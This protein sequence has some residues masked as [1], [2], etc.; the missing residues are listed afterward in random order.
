MVKKNNYTDIY[1]NYGY[2]NAK[3]FKK[4]EHIRVNI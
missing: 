1:N 4:T 3:K 2:S